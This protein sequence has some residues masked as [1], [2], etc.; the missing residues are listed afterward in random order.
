MNR[1]KTGLLLLLFLCAQLLA[2]F[3]VIHSGGTDELDMVEVNALTRSCEEAFSLLEAGHTGQMPVSVYDYAVLDGEGNI[4]YASDGDDSLTLR[5]AIQRRDTLVDLHT[6]GPEAGAQAGGKLVLRS[7][8][9]QQAA[10]LKGRLSLLLAVSVMLTGLWVALG[11]R[12]LDRTV[13]TPFRRLKAFAAR[14]AGG[15]LEVPLTMDRDN[16]FGA[17]TESFDLMR[18]ELCQARERERR[19]S[20][21]KKELVAKLSHDIK[22]PIASIRAV[23]EVM[24][25]SA[26]SEKEK[27]QLAVIE[28]KAD[29]VDSLISNLFHAALEELEELEV[30]PQEQDSRLLGE[31]LRQADYLK[32]AEIGPIPECLT[33]FDPLRMQ[34]VFDNLIGNSY[35]YAGTS[36]RVTA[37]LSGERIVVRIRDYG[38]GVP[39][40]ELPLLCG[41]YYRG[42]NSQGKTGAGLGLF[43][44][45]YLLRQMGGELVCENTEDGFQTCVMLKI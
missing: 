21:S 8:Y 16:V 13:F 31:L 4:L 38:P 39:P 17:F 1:R 35:K 20:Q 36:L 44:S 43:I 32:R 7:G 27:R 30:C 19:A 26:G 28:G 10:Q 25:V 41:K 29:Q 2:G 23:A 14:V 12:Y 11:V 5:R 45:R 18:H 34:Q 15:D 42:A 40:Q 24:A 37:A 33:L 22:T 9:E 6:A 3:I